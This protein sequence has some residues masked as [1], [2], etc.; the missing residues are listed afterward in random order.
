MAITATLFLLVLPWM[1]PMILYP[2]LNPLISCGFT[3]PGVIYLVT[4]LFQWHYS[5]YQLEIATME[6]AKARDAEAELKNEITAVKNERAKTQARLASGV[7]YLVNIN[8]A[9]FST[10]EALIS[11]GYPADEIKLKVE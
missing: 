10:E 9:D 2:Q 3:I 5:D 4:I 7:K 8:P 6:L 1:I 11:F